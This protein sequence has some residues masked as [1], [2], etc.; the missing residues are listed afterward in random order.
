MLNGIIKVKA[1][2]CYFQ[3]PG[4]QW[5]VLTGQSAAKNVWAGY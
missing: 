5:I 1:T 4:K 3:P 2:F